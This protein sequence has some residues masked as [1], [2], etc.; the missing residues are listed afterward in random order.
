MEEKKELGMGWYK[1]LKNWTFGIGIVISFFVG[2][3]AFFYDIEILANMEMSEKI[4]YIILVLLILA[5]DVTIKIIIHT[6]LENFSK[7]VNWC[8]II[9]IVYDL[10]CYFFL[11]GSPTFSVILFFSIFYFKKRKHIFINDCTFWGEVKKEKSH[12]AMYSPHIED[13]GNVMKETE[14][15]KNRF[16]RKCGTKLA[17]GSKFCHKCGTEIVE[18]SE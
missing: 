17:E 8:L 4:I 13:D 1:F 10:L 15:I 9:F 7:H 18:W 2:F 16:C 6:H 11:D 14:I 5:F 12:V 3:A